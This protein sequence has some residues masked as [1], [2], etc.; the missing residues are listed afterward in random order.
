[1]DDDAGGGLDAALQRGFGDDDQ[2]GDAG[3]DGAAVIIVQQKRQAQQPLVIPTLVGTPSAATSAAGIS[4]GTITPASGSLIIGGVVARD[5]TEGHV[6][7]TTPTLSGIAITGSWTIRQITQ[8]DTP[9]SR[10]VSAAIYMAVL[11]GATQNGTITYNTT[12]GVFNLIQRTAIVTAGFA[13]DPSTYPFITN[14]GEGSTSLALNLAS[15]PSA[16]SLLYSLAASHGEVTGTF[17]VPSG[18]TTLSDEEASG[19]AVTSKD[20]YKLLSGAQNNSWT[21]MDSNDALAGVL[22][23]ILQA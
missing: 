3:L 1:V 10:Y 6:T 13:S 22:V 7:W 2:A 5:D 20:S 21:G 4:S 15:A 11:S 9:D 16:T 14:S 17:T 23:E 8:L 12:D 19:T 18:H